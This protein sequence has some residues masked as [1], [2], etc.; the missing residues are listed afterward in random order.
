MVRL[1]IVGLGDWG[2]NFIRNFLDHDACEVRCLVDRDPSRLE[3]AAQRYP[4]IRVAGSLDEAMASETLDAVV[5]ATPAST[6]FSLAQQ[7]LERGLHVLVEKPITTDSGQA[8]RLA[9][10]A[11]K[12]N[13]V[14]MVGHVFVYNAGVQLIKQYFSD[15]LL[16]EL[17]YISMVRTNL[18]PI[19]MDVNAA[20]DLAAHDIAIA[21]Y[22]LEGTPVAA[23]AMGSSWINEGLVDVAFA[24][25]R[26]PNDVLVNL[27]ASWLN[28]RKVRHITVVAENQMLTFD[29]MEVAEPVRVYDKGVTHDTV[30]AEF[31]DSFATFRA[32]IREGDVTIPRVPRIEPLKAECAH[33]VECI[34]FGKTPLTGA[35]EGISVVRTLEAIERSVQ[36]AGRE[37]VV[38]NA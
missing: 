25:L 28:P 38:R 14:L 3:Q 8:L 15:A 27:H 31:V 7:A 10:L 21:N 29:D 22:W 37:E 20:W 6:H 19:R 34:Q 17:Y 4:D 2:P 36:G 24:S 18:G 11:Q 23:S 32:N 13:L 1:A 35:P 9:D 33:F 5:I 30:K 12:N 26:Y 16:G